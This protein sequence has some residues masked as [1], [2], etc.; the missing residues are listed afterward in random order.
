MSKRRTAKHLLTGCALTQASRRL[1]RF[2]LRVNRRSSP[3]PGR[4]AHKRSVR[5]HARLAWVFVCLIIAL[6]QRGST[7][8]PVRLY[9]AGSLRAAMTDIARAF[10]AQYGVP[11]ETTFGASGLLRERIERGESA[12]VFASADIQHPRTL[13]QAGKGGPVPVFIRNRLCVLAQPQVVITSETVLETLLRPDIR[14]GTSTPQA[15]PSGDYAWALFRLAERLRPGSYQVLDTK[16]L[17][18][19]GGP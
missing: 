16:A 18:L 17:K 10:T 11:V 6:P 3:T 13:M 1:P 9:A 19:T 2:V 15:D 7:E 8:E 5:M 14:L 4:M 12:D